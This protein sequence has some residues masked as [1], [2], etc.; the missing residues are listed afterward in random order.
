MWGGW[1]ERGWGAGVYTGEA[2]RV[3]AGFLGCTIYGWAACSVLG[4]LVVSWGTAQRF[5]RWAVSPKLASLAQDLVS[6]KGGWA[7]KSLRLRTVALPG[8]WP[9]WLGAWMGLSVNSLLWSWWV[10]KEGSDFLWM[11][12]L[13]PSHGGLPTWYS[14]RAAVLCWAWLRLGF[15]G[16][17]HAI[18]WW[19]EGHAFPV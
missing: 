19:V 14:S 15:P 10:P 12:S 11:P 1:G 4:I 5:R 16:C 2:G 9:W 7:R 13:C 17:L 8:W 18:S 3:V 6:M